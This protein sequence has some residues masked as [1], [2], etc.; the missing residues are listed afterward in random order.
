MRS[1]VSVLALIGV[2]TVTATVDVPCCLVVSCTAV[3]PAVDVFY[4]GCFV[5]GV[6]GVAKVSA[7]AAFPNMVRSLLLLVV[8]AL[9]ASLLLLESLLLL[10]SLLLLAPSC[11]WLPALAVVS[12]VAKKSAV[13]GDP[14]LAIILHL[15]DYWTGLPDW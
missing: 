9:L 5:P 8:P 2:S 13:A 4:Y 6:P 12:A 11:C 7:D 15:L 14:A 3:G 10:T 1:N